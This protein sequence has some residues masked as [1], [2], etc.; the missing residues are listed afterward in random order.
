MIKDI[1]QQLLPTAIS[2]EVDTTHPA[3]ELDHIPPR[4][5]SKSPSSV[6]KKSSSFFSSS[7]CHHLENLQDIISTGNCGLTIELGKVQDQ[8]HNLTN[9]MTTMSSQIKGLRNVVRQQGEEIRALKTNDSYT[10]FGIR[11]PY[12]RTCSRSQRPQT[13]MR[14]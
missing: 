8:L 5:L 9:L 4:Q 3:S 14:N 11:R 13:P 1:L 7:S 6:S 10:R 2:Q 12:A